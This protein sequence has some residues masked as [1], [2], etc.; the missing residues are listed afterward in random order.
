MCPVQRVDLDERDAETIGDRATRG[1][2]SRAA[3]ADDGDA[4]HRAKI[5]WRCY[6]RE[7]CGGANMLW[8]NSL[9]IPATV[10]ILISA[11]CGGSAAPATSRS[12][13]APASASP[14][15]SV[16]PAASAATKPTD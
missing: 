16:S 4:T 6:A 3:T 15:A 1:R 8:K 9:W 10:A 14:A 2:L 11:S 5:K 13:T 12:P 7:R